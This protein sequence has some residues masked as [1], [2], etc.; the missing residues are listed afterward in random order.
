MLKY[1]IAN[2]RSSRFLREYWKPI[3]PYM[4]IILKRRRQH[5]FE[6]KNI[7]ILLLKEYKKKKTSKS[8]RFTEYAKTE[9]V[10][11]PPSR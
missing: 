5:R 10:S 3:Y 8:K 1:N 4:T 9:T 11:R 6:K 7:K 2:I